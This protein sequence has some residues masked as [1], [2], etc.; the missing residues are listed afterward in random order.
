MRKKVLLI[1]MLT[2]IICLNA[3][4]YIDQL[5]KN[6]HRFSYW[7]NPFG[8]AKYSLDTVVEGV[9][10]GQL[11]ISGYSAVY[12]PLFF[13]TGFAGSYIYY[14]YGI[15]DFLS[16]GTKVSALD[17]LI[18]GLTNNMWILDGSIFH[19][20]NIYPELYSLLLPPPEFLNFL[21]ISL[22]TELNHSP[23][24]ADKKYEIW[25]YG[26]TNLFLTLD[27]GFKII[28]K[29]KF[30]LSGFIDLKYIRNMPDSEYNKYLFPED[31]LGFSNFNRIAIMPGIELNFDRLS[32]YAGFNFKLYDRSTYSIFNYLNIYAADISYFSWAN[33]FTQL[34]LS[35]AYKL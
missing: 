26:C 34:A 21:D 1:L 2:T 29:E 16:I 17:F 33:D 22:S 10:D 23:L 18:N 14:E 8:G 15:N 9:V 6:E 5:Q 3:H 4:P 31:I 35:W 7:F 28:Q 24:F 20:L 25:G 13:D 27:L 30:T 19:D 12:A 32:I 11:V